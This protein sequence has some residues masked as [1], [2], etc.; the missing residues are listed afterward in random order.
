VLQIKIAIIDLGS[1]SV[2]MNILEVIGGEFTI[3]EQFKEIV[4]L[5]EGMGAEKTLKPNAI[6]KMLDVMNQFKRKIDEYEVEKIYPIAT[7]AVRIANN[8]EAL[9]KP[10][11]R[12]GISLEV[13]TGEK[14]AYYDY[15]G[16]MNTL[17]I[18]DC[19]IIDTGGASTEI[20]L[21][22]DRIHYGLVS[23]P[24]GAVNITETYLKGKKTGQGEISVAKSAISEEL[25]KINWIN[26]AKN[27]PIVGLGGSIRAIGK[28][29]KLRRN[30]EDMPLHGF[31]MSDN[32]I[33]ALCNKLAK[34]SL[35]AR[36]KMEGIGKARADIIIGGSLPLTVLMRK[37]SSKSLIL[38]ASGL[39]EG[40]LFEILKDGKI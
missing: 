7:A 3:I 22:R 1:N 4:R 13:I 17:D 10:L 36:K 26:S 6:E 9:T 19:V 27:L 15:L 31:E 21:V 29:E 40:V 34:S 5:S 23:I 20:I 25:D 2:R 18:R 39:R 30:K 12:L 33:F 16:V 37:L 35:E 14:E 38:S 8:P 28:T 24:F 11:S 32:D